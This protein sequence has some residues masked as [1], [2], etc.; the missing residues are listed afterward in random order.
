M[1]TFEVEVY[2]IPNPNPKE[3][4]VVSALP[5]GGG[6]GKKAGDKFKGVVK[7]EAKSMLEACS[8]V[9]GGIR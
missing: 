5:L 6:I 9:M 2:L 3:P 7:V 4:P 1:D 8:R